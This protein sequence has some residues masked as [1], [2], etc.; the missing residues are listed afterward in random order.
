MMAW[1]SPLCTVRSRPFRISRP[2]TATWRFLISSIAKS[3]FLRV[4]SFLQTE[5]RDDLGD[6]LILFR[7]FV[8]GQAAPE[9]L[10]TDI[11]LAL[12][13]DHDRHAFG[14]MPLVG[15]FQHEP[16]AVEI[17]RYAMLLQLP[18]GRHVGLVEALEERAGR[19]APPLAFRFLLGP[20]R[21]ERAQ[22]LVELGHP[23]RLRS[24]D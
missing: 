18:R 5:M 13:A 12:F 19:G 8:A 7:G 3:F 20:P 17:G 4:G 15:P 1:T 10:P 24:A 11:D 14:K 6:Q 16:R 9:R 23:L 2:S 21:L 22:R